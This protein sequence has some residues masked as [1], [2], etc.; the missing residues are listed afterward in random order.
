MWD[1][2]T[3]GSVAVSALA[4]VLGTAALIFLGCMSCVG[5]LGFEPSPITISLSFGL[6]VMLIIQVSGKKDQTSFS[7][8]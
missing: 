5:S 3:L 8:F 1:E 7:Q 4:E 6:A 2:D